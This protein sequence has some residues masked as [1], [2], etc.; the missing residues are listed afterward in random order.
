MQINLNYGDTININGYT[1]VYEKGNSE[2]CNGCDLYEQLFEI[3]E[4]NILCGKDH[5]KRT[6]PRAI[7]S[8]P[9][10]GHT[11]YESLENSMYVCTKCE[12]EFLIIV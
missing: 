7:I 4:C 11:K 6:T 10:C 12:K 1:Y 9:Y 8:C 3:D 5:L 2:G